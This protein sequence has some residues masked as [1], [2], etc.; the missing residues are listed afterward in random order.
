MDKFLKERDW[1]NNKGYGVWAEKLIYFPYCYNV[2]YV[3]DLV[4]NEA[5]KYRNKLGCE[6]SN[7]NKLCIY[8]SD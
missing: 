1:G 8:N 5:R 6:I 3:T 4:I 2:S 7:S